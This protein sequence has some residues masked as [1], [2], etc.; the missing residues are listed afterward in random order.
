MTETGLPSFPAVQD[1][2]M[3]PWWLRSPSFQIHFSSQP[4][5][6][7]RG[8]HLGHS[9][10]FPLRSKNVRQA[11]WCGHTNPFWSS[12][13]RWWKTKDTAASQE[14]CS[15]PSLSPLLSEQWCHWDRSQV[16]SESSGG[17]RT[18]LPLTHRPHRNLERR[19]KHAGTGRVHQSCNTGRL[20]ACYGQLVWPQHEKG[21]RTTHLLL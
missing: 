1:E 11:P 4:E 18:C 21:S 2:D 16:Q 9:H 7:P 15:I 12:W 6:G 13:E 20:G 5:E 3:T 8:R 19:W 10:P 14:A 17:G